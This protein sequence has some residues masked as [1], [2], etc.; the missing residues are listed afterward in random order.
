M[1]GIAG[2]MSNRG[3]APGEALLD[4]FA[5]ALS[6][7]GPDGTGRYRVG[8][9]AM[10]QTRLGPLNP[11]M[12]LVS[13]AFQRIVEPYKSNLSKI[14]VDLRFKVVQVAQY[15]ERLR[16]FKFPSLCHSWLRCKLTHR[17]SR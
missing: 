10:V 8:G 4:A 3:A 2:F 7:R 5:G 9:V 13:P 6:H 17:L 12:L 15:E 11:E 16:D 1:C 14:G